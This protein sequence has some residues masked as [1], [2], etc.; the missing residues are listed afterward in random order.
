MKIV[1]D[2]A[3]DA[4]GFQVKGRLT[5]KH[6]N[7]IIGNVQTHSVAAIFKLHAAVLR[8]LHKGEM[9]CI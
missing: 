9:W 8:N 5:E 4:A 6:W 2:P 3:V 7:V 1:V